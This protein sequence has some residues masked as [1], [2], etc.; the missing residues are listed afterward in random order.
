MK[1]GYVLLT[2][3]E[4]MWAK[5]LVDVL[6]DNGVACEALS[7]NGAGFAIKT[8]IQD[9][10]KMDVDKDKLDEAKTLYCELFGE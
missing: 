9:T 3:K 2:E 10:Y 8:G 4:E 1:N 7:V 6:R 5:M